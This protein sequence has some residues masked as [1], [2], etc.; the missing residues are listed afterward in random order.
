M[1]F[2]FRPEDDNPKHWIYERDL[3][4]K[5][6]TTT[7]GDVDLRPF[8]SKRH[9]QGST[10]SCV[11][12]SVVKALEIKR[13][14]QHGHDAHKDLSRMAV[15]YLA[16]ELMFPVETAKDEGTY[17]SLACDVLRRFGVCFEEDWPF[18]MAHLFKAPSWSAM[19]KAYQNK[20]ESFYKIKST[21]RERVEE[22]IRCLQ[23]GNPVVFGTVVGDQWKGYGKNQ[24]LVEPT[25]WEGRH[26][27]VLVGFKDGTFLG[28]NSW[29]ERWGDDGFYRMDPGYIASNN[30]ADFWTIQA[31]WEM[32]K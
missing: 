10:N 7:S 27:T 20:I 14:M 25:E 8:S 19:R 15:Y 23:A 29:G 17:V 4:P 12:N 5:M 13:I 32:R 2:G 6:I 22:V 3:K 9:N 11:A 28:E 21:G 31:G 18:D 1:K 16:R 26:A 30:S 24:V